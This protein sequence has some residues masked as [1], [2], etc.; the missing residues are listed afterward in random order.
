M[1]IQLGDDLAELAKSTCLVDHLGT[2]ELNAVGL[3]THLYTPRRCG[4]AQ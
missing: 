2:E 3:H 4:E 1:C